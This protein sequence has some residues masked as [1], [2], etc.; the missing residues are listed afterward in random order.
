MGMM[1]RSRNEKYG[2]KGGGR[3]GV[4]AIIVMVLGG[5]RWVEIFSSVMFKHFFGIERMR[6]NGVAGDND[7]TRPLWK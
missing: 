5:W 7:L 4:L 2:E 1:S 6:G 3:E